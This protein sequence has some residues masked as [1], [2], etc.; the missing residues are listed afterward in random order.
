MRVDKNRENSG[1]KRR[2]IFLTGI[3]MGMPEMLTARAKEVIDQADCLIGAKRMLECAKRILPGEMQEKKKMM[4]EYRPEQIAEIIKAEKEDWKIGILLSGDIGFFSGAKKLEKVLE[5]F[6]DEVILV[7]G[8]SSIV[9]LSAKI[10]IAW[11]DAATISLHGKNENFI[12]TIDKREKTFLLLGGTDAGKVFYKRMLEYEM[13]EVKIHIGTNLSY[14]DECVRSGVLSDFQE[15]DFEGL[16]AVMVENPVPSKATGPHRKDE[17]FLRG[18]VPMTKAEIRAVS[19]AQ[20]EL[21]EDA[22]VYDIGAGT[23]SVSVEIALSG[24]KIKVYAIEKNPE[25][26][27]LIRQNR[28]KFRVDG[29]RIIEGNAPEVLEGLEMPTHVFIGGSSGNLRQ[30]IEKVT[31]ANPEVKI[32]LNAISLETLGEVME[33]SK[34]GLLKEIQVTQLSA[35]RSRILG[36]YH[37]MTGQNPVYIIRSERRATET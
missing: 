23:G 2:K 14:A 3:G 7:P 20:M 6:A 12:Q 22:V 29:I 26:V 11:E 34:D 19:V 17:E 1:E 28:K 36:D 13:N 30:I 31:A 27:E 9:Y 5:G 10:G 25:G 18:K 32:V 4:V 8:I 16:T 37:M 35:A 24:E 33:L 21:T 15:E